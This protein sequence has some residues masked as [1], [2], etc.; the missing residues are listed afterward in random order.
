MTSVIWL[1]WTTRASAKGLS[2]GMPYG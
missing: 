2:A 1:D